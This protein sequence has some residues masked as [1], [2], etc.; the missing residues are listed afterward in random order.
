MLKL[1]QYNMG[2]SDNIKRAKKLKEAKRQREKEAMV[3]AG[4][5]KPSG[6]LIKKIKDAGDIVLQNTSSLK[7]SQ[8]L[9]DFVSIILNEEDVN[10]ISNLESKL[11]FASQAWN[12]AVFKEAY[13]AE[14]FLNRKDFLDKFNG[15]PEVEK[16]FDELVKRKQEDF[17][18]FKILYGE[19][20]LK[21]T[22]KAGLVLTTEVSIFNP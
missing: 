14:Y 12:A 18:E 13:E 5:V 6:S 22:K 15:L 21:E 4:I 20:E 7:F 16:M 3:A 17:A 10:N 8:I 11:I 19:L 1:L 9:Q 2:K